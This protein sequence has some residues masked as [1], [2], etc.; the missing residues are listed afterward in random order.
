[1]A[2]EA[3]IAQWLAWAREMQAM[4][5]T[6]LAYSKSDYDTQK[7]TRFMEIAAEMTALAASL[8][9]PDVLEGFRIQP[10]YATVKV[11]VRGAVVHEGRILLVRET[12]DGRWAM[13]GGWADVGELP[14][15]M[16]QREILEESGYEARP[17]RVV[18][19]FDANRGGRPLEFFHAYKIVFLCELTGGQASTSQETSAVGFFPF[20]ALPPL[21]EHRTN[22]R[23]LGE[24]LRHLECPEAPVY[25]D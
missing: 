1:M 23:H 9:L 17:L 19:V 25:F 15:A 2:S 24:V 5:Q 20:D 10:G 18:G 8:P 21:S 7:Y 14:S 4:S 13:P 12:Q 6:G 16:I 11:D 3:H 22:S